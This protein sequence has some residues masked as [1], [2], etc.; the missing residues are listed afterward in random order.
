MATDG[1]LLF[2]Q[3]WY[4]AQSNGFWEHGNGVTIDLTGTVLEEK[5]MQEI[6]VQRS[7]KDWI[8]CK[9]DHN[10]FKGEGDP[11]K[12]GMILQIFQNWASRDATV[13]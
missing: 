8:V 7:A 2:L 10:Q 13:K 9:V 1:P 3:S 5:K 4:G 12:L 6:A 11:L